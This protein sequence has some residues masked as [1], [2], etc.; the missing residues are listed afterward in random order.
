MRCFCVGDIHGMIKPLSDL[1]SKIEDRIQPDDVTIF[2]GDY[3]DRGAHSFEVVEKI[4]SYSEKHKSIFLTGNHEMMLKGYLSGSSS[5]KALYMMNGGKITIRSYEKQF[6][7]FF[8]PENHRKVLFSE[9]YYCE[10]DS[11]I[12]VH[13]G[14]N[15]YLDSPEDNDPY[16]MV[17]IREEFYTAPR[18]WD[19][20]IVF[21][22]TPTQYLGMQMG[23][24]FEDDQ[25]N[26]IGIDTGAVYGGRL[27]CLVMPDRFI[28][29]SV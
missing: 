5:D 28:I 3:I 18:R 26:I 29:Q 22:H 13:A 14:L 7:D 15:P 12:V 25:K 27:T 2:C 4:I 16:E 20:T 11:F 6:G 17:W 19:K 9:I 24:V 1:M 23:E 8:I 21:G 10:Y